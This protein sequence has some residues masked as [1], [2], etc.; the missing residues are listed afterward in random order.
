MNWPYDYIIMSMLIGVMCLAL[1]WIAWDTDRNLKAKYSDS[2]VD[3]FLRDN[4]GLM[5]D[6]ASGE[7][8]LDS[9]WILSYE[10]YVDRPVGG[11]W[12]RVREGILLDGPTAYTAF[13]KLTKRIEENPLY[14]RSAM[15]ERAK[16]IR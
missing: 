1:A 14:M 10:V 8:P 6:L 13:E 3:K 9:V 2:D 15:C 7:M 12:I 4:E 16:V 11:G 5:N